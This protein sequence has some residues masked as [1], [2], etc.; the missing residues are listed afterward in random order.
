MDKMTQSRRVT[1]FFRKSTPALIAALMAIGLLASASRCLAVSMTWTNSNDVWTSLTAWTTNQATGIDPVSLTN[2]TCGVGSVS[3]VTA[4]CAGGTGGFPGVADTADFTNNTSYTVTVN[5]PTTVG[6]ATFSNSTGAVTLNGSGSSLT[7]TG[8][9]RVADG[10]ATSTVVWAGGTLNLGNSSS[11]TLQIGSANSNSLGIF[12]V[13]NGTVFT[14]GNVSMGTPITS[15]GKIVI[16]GPGIVTNVV[17]MSL[18]AD[19]VF[20][21]RTSGSAI[22]VTNG[23]KLF[24]MGEVRAESNSTILVSDPNSFLSCSN[25][26]GKTATFSIGDLDGPGNLLI[27][28]NGATVFSDGTISIGRNSGASNTGLVTGAGSQLISSPNGSFVVGVGSAGASDDYLGVDNGGFINCQGPFFS[29]PGGSDTNCTFAMGGKGLMS[30]GLAIAVRGNSLGTNSLI[31]IT[32]AVFTC[33]QMS[34]QGSGNNTLTVLSKGTLIFSNQYAASATLTNVLSVS[35]PPGIL[36]INGG[37][38]NAV[39]SSNTMGILVGNGTLTGNS[40][41]IIGGGKLLSEAA[42][43]GANSS[44]STGIVSGVSSIWSNVTTG[45]SYVNSNVLVIGAGTTSSGSFNYLGV[46]NGAT[47]VNNGSLNIGNGASSSFNSVL[48]GGAGT[49]ATIINNGLVN[50]GGASGTSGNTLTITNALLD[51][52]TLN[53]GGAGTNRINNTV[54]FTGGTIDANEVRVRLSNTLV[55]TAGTLSSGGTDIDPGANGSNVFVVGDGVSPAYFDMSPGGDGFHGFSNGGLVV[56][57][58]ASLRGSGTLTGTIAVLGTFVPGFANAVGSIFSSNSLSFGNSAVL[59]Y[60]LGTSS[61]SVT[62]NDNLKLG[63]T[64]N[65]TDTGGFGAGNYTLFT[66]AG[67]LSASGTLTVGSTPNGSLTYVIKTNMTGVVILQVSGGSDPFTTWQ[68]LYF[69]GST[70]NSA[71]TADPLGKGMSNTNQFLAGFNPTNAAAYVHI[72]SVSKT[73]SGAGI[74]VDYLGASGD[75]TYTGGPGSRTNVLEFTAG[76]AGSYNSNTFASTGQTNILSGGIGLGT[77]T[78]MVDPGGAA[79]GA[80]R[81]YRVRVLVP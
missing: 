30:T 81:Y 77:L 65:I 27:V 33:S 5:T 19:Y 61:D 38:I 42:T 64:L 18:A 37:T 7:V 8:R 48:F 25:T 35:A 78:N 80:T 74:R 3:N 22:I 9:F 60:D 45:V 59:N 44:F 55:F 15:A 36:T 46:Q 67:T 76:T 56:T 16:S 75:S 71:G 40:M 63:G 58:G 17:G 4:T 54:F 11:L 57:N 73:N 34:L 28:S 53:V 32:N 66:Y 49:P 10:G 31:V 62:V 29:V 47:L 79:A 6:Y 41:T 20:R 43:I 21:A 39:S 13:T 72:T 2:I 12:I 23:G 70:L 50:V 69:N 51:C 1:R 26:V 24:W 14:Q 68:T 52:D